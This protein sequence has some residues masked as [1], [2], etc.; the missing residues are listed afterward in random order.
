LL[1]LNAGSAY[2][3][4]AAWSKSCLSV[5]RAILFRLEQKHQ[6]GAF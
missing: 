5:I 6:V 4:S 3:C 1:I 2:S